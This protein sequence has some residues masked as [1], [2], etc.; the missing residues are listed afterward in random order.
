MLKFIILEFTMVEMIGPVGY[1]VLYVFQTV[2][3]VSHVK[4][5]EENINIYLIKPKHNLK[6]DMI[7]IG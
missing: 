3:I 4:C 1:D 2:F 5:L 6:H 7:E